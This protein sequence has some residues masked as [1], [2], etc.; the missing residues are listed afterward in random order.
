MRSILENYYLRVRKNLSESERKYKQN[1][2]K[3]KRKKVYTILSWYLPADTA[4]TACKQ[5]M[6]VLVWNTK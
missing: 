5:I 3:Q 1:D 6:E 4:K 2:R